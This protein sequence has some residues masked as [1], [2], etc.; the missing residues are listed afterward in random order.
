M[1]REIR[2]IPRK[3]TEKSKKLTHEKQFSDVTEK[4]LRCAGKN[5]NLI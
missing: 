1:K 2:E 4:L 5:F 3:K